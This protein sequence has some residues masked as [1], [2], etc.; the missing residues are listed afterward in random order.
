MASNGRIDD[1]VEG[2][3]K[4]EWTG[5]NQSTACS[6]FL[7]YS[8]NGRPTLRRRQ[9]GFMRDDAS[10]ETSSSPAA[11]NVVQLVQTVMLNYM[12]LHNQ[13]E[14]FNSVFQRLGLAHGLGSGA[15]QDSLIAF[16]PVV[17]GTIA[18]SS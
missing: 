9:I 11:N 4:T 12:A 5:D 1:T 3:G 7:V 18:P 8:P 13:N 6:F 14:Q 2:R 16:D 17:N 10:V 15:M